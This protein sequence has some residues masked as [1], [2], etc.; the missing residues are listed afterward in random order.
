MLTGWQSCLR[1]AKNS[2]ASF[3]WTF[4]PGTAIL[5]VNLAAILVGGRVWY[6]KATNAGM[7]IE[8]TQKLQDIATDIVARQD[9]RIIRLEAKLDDERRKQ[10][11][12]SLELA[13]VREY[14]LRDAAWHIQV[15]AEITSLGGSISAAPSLPPRR[16]EGNSGPP[17]P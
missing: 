10:E 2:M 17:A 4:T 14:I 7:R 15:L 16:N 13:V 3:E 8:N 11:E 1:W 12:G 6:V 9:E 5:A